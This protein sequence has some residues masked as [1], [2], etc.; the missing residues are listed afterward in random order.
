MKDKPTDRLSKII[1]SLAGDLIREN[2]HR[3]QGPEGMTLAEKI[4]AIKRG[5]EIRYGA[6]RNRIRNTRNKK[7]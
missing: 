3:L 5:A 7:P 2:T 4:A 1:S 6:E